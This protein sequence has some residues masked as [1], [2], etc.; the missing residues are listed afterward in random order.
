M[1]KKGITWILTTGIRVVIHEDGDSG[2][3]RFANADIGN[4]MMMMMM[5][6]GGR[7]MYSFIL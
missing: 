1:D 7:L 3:L 4:K 5:Q 6:W 2:Y